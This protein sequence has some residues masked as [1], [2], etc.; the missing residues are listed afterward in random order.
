MIDYIIL[1]LPDNSS[2]PQFRKSPW[3]QLCKKC[4]ITVCHNQLGL[5]TVWFKNN[6]NNNN[7]NSIYLY[8]IKK[9]SRADVVVLKL[10]ILSKSLKQSKTLSL[11]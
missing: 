6:N 3:I 1:T 11:Q 7:N 10:K 5:E 4:R 8:T 2:V 9:Y